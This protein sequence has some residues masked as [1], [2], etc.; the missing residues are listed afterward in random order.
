VSD[1]ALDELLH[2]ALAHRRAA[3]QLRQRQVV[4]PIDSTHVEIEG[5]RYANFCSNNYLGLTHHPR[6]VEAVAEA[7][8]SHGTGAGAAPLIS[9]YTD[10]HAS[11]ERALASW[12]GT[13]SA[14]LLP[15]GYQAN[16]AAI[17][18]TAS[19]AE[20]RG[21]RVRFLLD[22][23]AHASLIDAVRASALPFR[24]FP[25]NDLSKLARLLTD[26]DADEL[27]V[28]VT[29][30][31]FSMDGDASPL[32]G[33]A[34]LKSRHHFVFLL[35]EAHGSG[36]YGANGSGF[37]NEVALTSIV[38]IFVVTL[39][40]SM[41][42]AG[43]AVCASKIFCD[44]LI[45]F[46]RAYVFSTSV[47]PTVAAACEAAIGVMTD[48]PDRQSR[49]RALAKRV[50]NDLKLSGDSPIIPI[51]LGEEEAAIAA[52]NA[53]R[54]KGMLV[55]PVRPPTVPR[56]TSRLRVT[57]SCDHSDAEIDALIRAL[58][59]LPKQSRQSPQQKTDG[60]RPSVAKGR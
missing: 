34:E 29:E 53:L 38:D 41:G 7:A 9:G 56:G 33:F 52:A 6:V 31:I 15:S 58:A 10:V 39:S 32:A 19:V 30:S 22:K 40:K 5:R 45:N 28:V 35:D 8:Q 16:L 20:A 21:R 11:A 51:V 57:L 14:V 1:R 50:R 26:K 4:R 54:E 12:K 59:A 25:H 43:G 23:L 60:V 3:F 48:E 44:A 55:L 49:V 17:Q 18:T 27:Q 2:A 24:V 36:V 37:A 42:C 13:E 46:G 47:P